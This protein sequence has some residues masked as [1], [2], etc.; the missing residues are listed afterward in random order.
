ME[1]IGT[2]YYPAL[3]FQKTRPHPYLLQQ[4]RVRVRKQ[5][6]DEILFK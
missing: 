2:E 6:V 4:E 1:I 3:L 5:S